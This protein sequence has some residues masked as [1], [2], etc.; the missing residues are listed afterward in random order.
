MKILS[1][2]ES[3]AE[4]IRL[5]SKEVPSSTLVIFWQFIL[6]GI[7]ELSIVGNQILSLEMLIMKLIH[8]KGMPSFQEVLNTKDENKVNKTS[9]IPVDLNNKAHLNLCRL[10]SAI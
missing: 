1:I 7:E 4:S 5:I 8:L 2:S 3:E 6:K 10:I 9:D